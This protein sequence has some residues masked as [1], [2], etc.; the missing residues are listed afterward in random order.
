MLEEMQTEIEDYLIR[1][2]ISYSNVDISGV[3]KELIQKGYPALEVV[4]TSVLHEAVDKH[5]V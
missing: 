4:L 3:A 1:S 2:E 5:R